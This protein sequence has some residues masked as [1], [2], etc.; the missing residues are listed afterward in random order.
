MGSMLLACPLTHMISI[1]HFNLDFDDNDEVKL[2]WDDEYNPFVEEDPV[3]VVAAHD[4]FQK[5]IK[6][7]KGLRPKFESNNLGIPSNQFEQ[8]VTFL[9]A[10]ILAMELAK[11]SIVAYMLEDMNSDEGDEEGDEEE[12]GG[13]SDIDEESVKDDVEDAPVEDT[14]SSQETKTEL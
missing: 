5:E 12:E 2:I 11:E 10:N 6:R 13:E 1:Q 7:L 9:E 3:E 8:L 4:W 14:E